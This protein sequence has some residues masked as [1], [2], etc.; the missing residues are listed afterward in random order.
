VP[1]RTNVSY[2]PRALAGL[3]TL[4]FVGC[5]SNRQP[6]NAPDIGAAGQEGEGLGPGSGAGGSTGHA[7]QAGRTPCCTPAAGSSGDGTGGTGVGTVFPPANTGGAAGGVGYAGTW[8]GGGAGAGGSLAGGPGYAGGSGSS[9]EAGFP[10]GGL[11]HEGNTGGRGVGLAG[12]AGAPTAKYS[13]ACSVDSD[14]PDGLFCR[15]GS[16]IGT[17]APFCSD[18]SP[19]PLGF[20]CHVNECVAGDVG[21]CSSVSACEHQRSPP[22]PDGYS[23]AVPVSCNAVCVFEAHCS[24]TTDADC[25]APS[26]CDTANAH[27]RLPE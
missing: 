7:G 27:C 13:D 24:C 5:F 25:P 11:G 10:S 1:L 12:G 20:E 16:C 15:E 26:A 21:L 23:Y 22:C 17:N 9:G 14:C 18:T 8:S 6:L 2:S 4:L 19:C 3:C